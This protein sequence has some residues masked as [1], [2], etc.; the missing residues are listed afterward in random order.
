MNIEYDFI[1]KNP[2]IPTMS[3][4]DW[5]I[6]VSLIECHWFDIKKPNLYRERVNTFIRA[7][8]HWPGSWAIRIT[9][10]FQS[11]LQAWQYY[12]AGFLGAGL[13][14]TGFHIG[15]DFRAGGA[16]TGFLGV[17]AGRGEL[18]VAWELGLLETTK[19]FLKWPHYL[20]RH[21]A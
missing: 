5:K 2:A 4:L 21:F 13:L 11:A 15:A 6:M 1:W 9:T 10:A 19:L 18:D 17:G 14:G 3:T 16:T 8:E 12:L 20:S 7:L